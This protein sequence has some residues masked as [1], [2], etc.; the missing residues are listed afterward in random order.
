MKK[1]NKLFLAVCLAALGVNLQ[2]KV[3]ESSVATVNG[4]PVLAS[5]YDTYLEGVVEQYQAAAPQFLEK[6]YAKDVLGREVL[7]EL[8]SKEL[9]YQAAEEQKIQVKDSELD[10]G[11]NEIK[12]RFI[13][14]EVTGKQDPKGADKRFNEALKKQGMSFKTYKKKL[15]KDIAV[16]K[17]M[18]Q[19]LQASVKPVEEADAKALYANVEAVMKNNTKKI[20]AL[21]KEDPVK[22]KEAQAIAAKLQQ[23]TAEQVR[24]GHIYLAVT[25]DMKPEDVKKK[26]ELAKQ[27]KKEIDGGLD[28]SAA[29][30]KYTEDKNALASGGDMILIKGVAPKAIDDKA[31]T[32]AV[33]KVS[34]PIKSDVGFHIIKIKEKRA[35]K[36]ISYD[37]ISKDLAQYLAQQRVQLAMGEYIEELYN[38]ADVKI[39]KTFESDALL[40]EAAAKA[41]QAEAK[42]AKAKTDTKNTKTD[43]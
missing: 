12:T 20:K 31:F 40:E 24:I 8:I 29:V 11:V 15:E 33:G 35:E 5:E 13:I 18:E 36:S 10:A 9:L 26:E 1:A 38:K 34:A 17:L 16:R 43:K 19:Q 28:F 3:M 25:K 39:T 6:P 22:L 2:A 23:L 37:D 27:I 14:D 21:E 41:A 32:L 4:R 7:K 30:K 42:N